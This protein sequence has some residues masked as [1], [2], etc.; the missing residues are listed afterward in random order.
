MQKHGTKLIFFLLI[1]SCFQVFY[2]I[3]NKSNILGLKISVIN[4][5]SIHVYKKKLKTNWINMIKSSKKNYV[6]YILSLF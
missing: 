3:N 2:L 6:I 5:K 1:V 4:Y